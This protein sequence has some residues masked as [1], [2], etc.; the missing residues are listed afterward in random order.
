[1]NRLKKDLET[2]SQEDA[3]G[4][5]AVLLL[6]GLT[7]RELSR[8]MEMEP[9]DSSSPDHLA[10]SPLGR[11]ELDEVQSLINSLEVQAS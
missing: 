1:M 8:A 9:G 7:H 6:L 2:S 11:E 5:D 10:S 3:R 4:V